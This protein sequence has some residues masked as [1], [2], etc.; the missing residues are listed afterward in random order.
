MA[1]Q[2]RLFG[3]D[4]VRGRAN[5][6]L[7]V[8]LA[9]ALGRAAGAGGGPV[10]VGRDTRRSGPMLASGLAAGLQSVGVDVIDAGVVPSGAVSALTRSAGAAY[11]AVVSAS[12]NPAPDNGIKFFGR[13]G[14]KLGDAQ[15]ADIEKRVH[16][17][18]PWSLVSGDDIGMLQPLPDAL[19][20]YVD[21]LAQRFEYSMHGFE[22]VLDCANGAAFRAAPQLF[23]KLKA[24]VDVIN[25]EP[26]GTNIN[27]R[28]GATHPEY[29]AR[30]VGGRLG[31]AFDGDAD[32]LVAVDEEGVPANG[33]V[34][35]AVLA[36]HAK[37][38]GK[39]TN[40]RVVSTVM[41]NL[42]FRLAMDRLGI[43]M[44][45][46]PVGDRYVLEA[47]I[48]HDAVL[49]GEQ[50]G[51]VILEDR[52]TGDGLA[53]ALRLVAVML[54]TGRRLVD[55]RNVI[56]EY[57]QVLRNVRVVGRGLDDA[58]LVWEAVQEVEEELGTDGR[59]LV[60]ASGTEPLVRVMVEAATAHEAAAHADRLAAVVRAEMGEPGPESG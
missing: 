20:R 5:T 45:E 15:E 42:G 10:V 59:V 40:N 8:D 4:G 12:H 47:M 24:S 13:D 23:E 56:T 22:V 57:P 2:R 32:R 1:S 53:T 35:M 34:I 6:E 7:T 38:M 3:T 18:G 37:E 44:L 31:L 39:L 14:R 30:R 51:H 43:E 48:E 49:G 9:V 21:M 19:D 55:L 26:D 46:T 36:A 54:A 60:R 50:S 41:A 16:A 52:T 33:D 27:H 29:L 25:A 17:G 28:C 11:G 58:T